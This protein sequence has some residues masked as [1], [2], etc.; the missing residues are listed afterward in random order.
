MEVSLIFV[1]HNDEKN[2][3]KV[4]SLTQAKE[5]ND[6]LLANGWKHTATIDPRLWIEYLFNETEAE[7]IVAEIRELSSCVAF[8][9][10]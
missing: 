8:Q 5:R 6:D 2:K 7:D 3:I 9:K 1:Y 10:G 4:L